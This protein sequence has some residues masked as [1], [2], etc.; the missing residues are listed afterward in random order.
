MKSIYIIIKTKSLV[1]M[2]TFPLKEFYKGL[3]DQKRIKDVGYY[4]QW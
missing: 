4:C 2:L 1:V 3:F